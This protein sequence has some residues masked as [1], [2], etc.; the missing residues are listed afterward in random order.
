MSLFG[1][2]LSTGLMKSPALYRVLMT[3]AVVVLG[4][5]GVLTHLLNIGHLELYQSVWTWAGAV[6]VNSFGLALNLLAA[7]GCFTRS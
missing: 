2:F 1:L 5:T 6:G 3:V 4:Y 7:F